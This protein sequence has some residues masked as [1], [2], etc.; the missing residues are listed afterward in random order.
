MKR[1][2]PLW[3]TAVVFTLISVG[4]AYAQRPTISSFSP[5]SGNIGTTVTITGTNFNAT[6]NQNIV[7]FGATKATVTAASTTSLTVTVPTG[8]T[9]QPISV[10]NL[11]TTLM[12][13]S[14]AP[15]RVTFAGGAI[16]A[17]SF[18]PEVK[19]NMDSPSY[20]TNIGDLDGDGKPDL[21]VGNIYGNTISVFRNIS[22]SGSI[23]SSSFES[24]VEFTTGGSPVDV[25]I[26]DLD[27]DG[28]LDLVVT[29]SDPGSSSSI[30]VFRNT[31]SSGIIN[32]SSFASKVDFITEPSPIGLSIGDLDGDGKPDLAVANSE[33]ISN[34]ISIFRNTSSSGSINSGSFA[35]KVN[36]TVGLAPA[37]L[38]IGDLDGDGK[39]DLVVSNYKSDYIS[40]LRNTASSGSINSSSFENKVDFTTGSSSEPKPFG[41]SIGDLD[42]DDKPDLVVANFNDGIISVLRNTASSG[43]I[44]S[45]SFASRV[46]FDAGTEP[47]SVSIG[48]LDGD[49]KPDLVASTSVGSISVIRNTASNGSITSSS[50]ANK[51][52]IPTLSLPINI[53]I[54]DLDGDG[55]PDL[56]ASNIAGLDISLIHNYQSPLTI[57]PPGSLVV[58]S[59]STLTLTA[60]GCAG[61]VTWSQ[62]AATGTSLTLSAV[63]TYSITATCTV[64]GVTSAASSAVTGLEIKAKPNAPSITP[65]ASL[66]VFTPSTLTLT[67]NGCAGTVTWSQGAAT[68]T[69]LTLSTV[70]IYSVSATC[71]V[72]G[73]ISD[74]SSAV[75]GLEIKS[76]S[77][78]SSSPPTITSFSPTSGDIGTSITLTGTNFNATADQNIVFFGATKATVTAASATSLTVTVPS[79]ATYQP[80]SVL[81]LGTT[82]MANSAAPFRVT[83]AG[84]VIDVG[85]NTFEPQVDFVTGSWNWFTSI[86]DLDGDGKPDLVVGNVPFFGGNTI[87][88]FRNIS[89][90]GSISSSS[91]E[92]KVEFSTGNNGPMGLSIADLDGDGKPDL[93]V[94]NYGYP[95]PSGIGNTI[96]V[97]RN[98]SSIGSIN[99]SSFANKVD[100]TTG[101]GPSGLSI[102]DLD[103]DGKPDL[104]VTN[105]GSN[106]NIGNTIS[107]LR[108]TSSRG[109][110]NSSSFAPKVDFTTDNGPFNVSIGDLDGDGK[111]DLI[112]GN[113]NYVD[114]ISTIS[115]FRNTSSSGSIT[116][117]SFAAKVDFISDSLASAT[118]VAIGD[119][120]GDDKPD[121]VVNNFDGIS[122]FR[123][124][125]SNGSINSSSFENEVDFATDNHSSNVS[126]SDLDGDSKPDLLVTF[127]NKISLFRNTA[128]IGSFT[129][130]SFASKVDFSFSSTSLSTSIADLDGDN[131][132]DLVVSNG[133]NSTISVLR[134]NPKPAPPIITP[135]ASLSVCS[136]STLTLTASECAG[137]VTWSEGAATGTSLTLS[138]IGTYSI[139]ATCTA[140]GT[141]SAASSAI[142]GLEI[143]TKPNAPSI[144]PPASL[145]VFTPSTLTLTASGCGGTVT[146]SEGLATGTSLTLSALGTYSVSATCTVNGCVSDASSAVTGLEIKLKPNAPTITPPASLSVCSPS[147]LTLTSSGCEGTVTWSEGAV[148]GTSLTLSAVG[149]YSISATCTVAGSMSDPSSSVTGLEIKAQ[150]IISASNTG[151][152]TIG[153]TISLNGTGNGTYIWTGPNNFTSTLSNPTINNA[154]SVNAGVYTLT[155]TGLNSCSNTSTT[156][157]VVNEIDPCDPTRI[158]DYFYVKAGNPYQTLFQLTDGMVINQIRDQVSILAN[159]VCSSVTI[160]SMEMNIQGPE[161][162]WN[163]LQN[164]EPNALFD[165]AGLDFFGR[166]FNPGNYTLTVTGYARDN[167]GGGIT[168]GPKII[169]FTVVG[170]LATINAPTLSKTSI[171][172]GSSVDVTFATSGTF[173]DINQYLIELSDT[174]GSFAKPL[175]I[176]TTNVTGTTTCLIPQNTVG[177]SK[178]LIRVV[179]S[180]QV[181]VSNPVISQVTVNPL[182]YSLV[183]PT[184]NLTGASTKKAI[185]SISASNKITSPANVVYQAGKSV[186][187]TPGFESGAVFRA[188]VKSC[189]N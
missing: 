61:T 189:D 141:T 39:P 105:F 150:P 138:A 176:G 20:F 93:V 180:N 16:S 106:T 156:N 22:S 75:T 113:R 91:F 31:A 147:T 146:W 154:L 174:S 99:S 149:T 11:G 2:L 139:S 187:L 64:A 59:P 101:D 92:S 17:T 7:F 29:N 52:D 23:S 27:G 178:Y 9:Y 131:K 83:F 164:A 79:G 71:T 10:L 86:G 181:V 159:P 107:V 51:I 100:F 143:K 179:S 184:N 129:S 155:V 177:G 80:I 186:L 172:A 84:G 95:Y 126:I 65:P 13:N 5:A 67:A 33:N 116:S 14:A 15:F 96:S 114:T 97:F 117:G 94:T 68:G 42:G 25:N 142:T 60:S 109:S 44:T 134:N 90:S 18:K 104:V 26:G 168:Y 170:N 140:A 82:L 85:I 157:V 40:V 182:N 63:G 46:N 53:K 37:Y 132:P 19:F 77:S 175:L 167:K 12:A 136:P 118:N 171:C 88:V 188:E 48:D 6:A 24:K 28:K 36:F 76:I 49:G 54:G 130:S 151:P 125:A 43:S 78:S 123:N 3:F 30:S 173:N 56:V 161:L 35:G 153:Q 185:D 144:V 127:A 110:I 108:N 8:A 102:S 135:P 119:L 57:T 112:V 137:T 145:L 32:S 73:C 148:T 74:A 50:F 87:S 98:T 41:L 89:S 103:G 183:S 72:N 133:V 169:R 58:C 121:I 47:Y 66:S 55:K 70:G 120:D 81:N 163:T 124:T 152:Y 166:N 160:E 1:Q 115:V 128:S 158:V 111:P 4:L 21:V 162:N 38:S 45:S 34:T 62:G 69:S 165:N 122:I